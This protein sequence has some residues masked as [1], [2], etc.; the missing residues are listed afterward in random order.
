MFL[1]PAGP[2]FAITVLAALGSP[3]AAQNSADAGRASAPCAVESGTPGPSDAARSEQADPAPA[4]ETASTAP[5]DDNPAAESLDGSDSSSAWL[6][7]DGSTAAAGDDC[8][9]D[10]AE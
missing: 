6:S 4:D 7:A 8:I 2:L 9:L 1:H 5:A 3:V 10:R